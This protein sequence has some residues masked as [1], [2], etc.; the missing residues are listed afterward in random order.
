MGRDKAIEHVIVY[1]GPT[2]IASGLTAC[3]G[4]LSFMTMDI[5]P[6][7]TFG[8]LTVIGVFVTLAL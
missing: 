8:L 7:R 2:V 3:G 6:I 5:E 4:L 1:L